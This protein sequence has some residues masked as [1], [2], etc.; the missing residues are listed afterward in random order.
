MIQLVTRSWEAIQTLH[1]HIWKVV[2]WV[3]ESAGKS[4]A[5]GL[6]IALCLVDMLPTIPL[7]L[8]FNTVTARLPGCTPE[9][10]AHASPLSTD[11][12]AMTV[13]G[14]EILKGACGAE[15][16]A[17]QATWLVTV[18]DAG[19]VKVTMVESEG[20]AI[21]PTVHARLLLRPY[22]HPHPQ[23]SIPL[24]NIHHIAHH[25]L[26]TTRHLETMS[27][28]RLEIKATFFRF[29]CVRF[30]QLKPN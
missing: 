25:T 24:D 22:M 10:H 8:T 20:S 9:A 2:H 15:E 17:M 3:M 26:P 5:D 4:M 6:G 1:E 30:W 18:T 16:K 11:R 19:S 29:Q 12:G 7:Q 28:S 27:L 14:K 21:I 13:L 23:V